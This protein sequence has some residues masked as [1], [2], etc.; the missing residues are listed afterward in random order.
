MQIRDNRNGEWYWVNTAVLKCPHITH[1]DKSVYSALATFSGCQEIHPNFQTISE[2]ADVSERFVK[3][4]IKKLEEVGYIEIR[5]GGGRGNAN[6]YFLLKVPKGCRLCTVSKGCKLTQKRVQIDAIKGADYSPQ[7]NKEIDKEINNKNSSNEEKVFSY[8]EELEKL[9]SSSRKDYK[10]IADYLTLKGFRFENK[11]QYNAHF[12]RCLKSAK[13]LKGYNQSQIDK[14]IQ[15][16]KKN[17]PE[18][19]METMVKRSADVINGL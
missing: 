9:K 14:I 11:D 6:V 3:Q 1:A 8:K 5:R 2:R 7:Y 16:C 13:D 4:S 19:T 17:Y 15:H 10:I 12:R 18:W